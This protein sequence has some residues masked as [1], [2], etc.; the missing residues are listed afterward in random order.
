M[1]RANN[2]D[3]YSRFEAEYED[4][5]SIALSGASSFA[6]QAQSVPKFLQKY[7]ILCVENPTTISV[8]TRFNILNNLRSLSIEILKNYPQQIDTE[9][10]AVAQFFRNEVNRESEE[11][12]VDFAGMIQSLQN[13]K[14]IKDVTSIEDANGFYYYTI[15]EHYILIANNLAYT[16]LEQENFSTALNLIIKTIDCWRLMQYNSY[17][18]RYQI[19]TVLIN[20][21][22]LVEEDYKVEASQLLC[23]SALHLENLEMEIDHDAE[24]IQIYEFISDRASQF[25][26]LLR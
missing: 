11:I 26:F 4:V 7:A 9:D 15:L 21:A 18:L 2:Q 10:A 16:C 22:S 6:K 12:T 3:I 23:N 17:Y 5:V 13:L 20:L 25:L 1:S 19:S 14:N 8:D 24:S